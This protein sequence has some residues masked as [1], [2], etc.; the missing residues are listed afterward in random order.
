MILRKPSD[1]CI[2]E[3]SESTMLSFSQNVRGGGGGAKILGLPPFHPPQL[4]TVAPPT[5]PQIDQEDAEKPQSPVMLS[6][7]SYS[8]ST[9]PA[10][11]P[12]PDYIVT[13][14]Q[15]ESSTVIL[16]SGCNSSSTTPAGSPD[17]D[18]I[19]TESQEES[20]TEEEQGLGKRCVYLIILPLYIL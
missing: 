2:L 4:H 19:Q 16:S 15:E 3:H 7:E 9:T 5:S 6:S 13:E 11:S 8:S 10:G 20:S 18:Y 12:D 17:P 1:W 14:S